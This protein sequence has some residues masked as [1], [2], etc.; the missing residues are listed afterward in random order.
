MRDSLAMWRRRPIND[1]VSPERGAE[2]D[3]KRLTFRDANQW[4][5][6]RRC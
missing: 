2:L 1:G 4:G 6:V 3:S 5:D